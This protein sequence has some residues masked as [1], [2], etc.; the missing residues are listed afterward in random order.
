MYTIIVLPFTHEKLRTQCNHADILG[1]SNLIIT[2]VNKC[3]YEDVLGEDELWATGTS[4]TIATNRRVV[5]SSLQGLGFN[6]YYL[7]RKCFK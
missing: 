4:I 5:T 2:L 6:S 3:L 7:S 1:G